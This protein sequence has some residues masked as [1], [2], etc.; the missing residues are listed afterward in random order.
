MADDTEIERLVQSFRRTLDQV[1]R[2]GFADG[3]A[4]ARQPPTAKG[5]AWTAQRKRE[6][7]SLWAA[8]VHRQEILTYLNSLPGPRPITSAD[9]LSSYAQLHHWGARKRGR[10][11][12]RHPVQDDVSAVHKSS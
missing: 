11:Q 10:A 12:K 9:A 7:Q 8:G 4:F 3:Q 1:Y 2:K 5:T 6:G